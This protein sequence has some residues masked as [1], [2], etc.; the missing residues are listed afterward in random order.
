[1]SLSS[2]SEDVRFDDSLSLDKISQ[3]ITFYYSF[4]TAASSKHAALFTKELQ[5]IVEIQ[6]CLTETESSKLYRIP[7][8]W[9]V[10]TAREHLLAA[11]GCGFEVGLAGDTTK[12][13]E[14]Q[15]LPEWMLNDC[16]VVFL[17]EYLQRTD[18]TL[19]VYLKTVVEVMNVIPQHLRTSKATQFTSFQVH[20]STSYGCVWND[21]GKAVYKSQTILD[22]TEYYRFTLQT[23]W[24]KNM[25]PF[26]PNPN[27]MIYQQDM[28]HKSAPS[29]ALM[30]AA[31]NP[32]MDGSMYPL[33][34]K[35]LTGKSISLQVN[36]EFSIQRVKELIQND[37]GIPP[38]QQTLIFAGR[39]LNN[40]QTL[41]DYNIQ[42]YS[43]LHL[44]LRCRGGMLH[45][46]SGRKGFD[47]ISKGIGAEIRTTVELVNQAVVESRHQLLLILRHVSNLRQLIA[48]KHLMSSY[49]EG[50]KWIDIPKNLKST[51][52]EPL[53]NIKSNHIHSTAVNNPVQIAT[54]LEKNVV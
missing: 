27:E 11:Y 12:W 44:V 23:Q 43:T 38:D 3:L 50:L 19:K 31:V 51:I 48:E 6:I 52:F 39:Q 25:A 22:L 5:H 34:V 40:P 35:T 36:S 46:I 37:E 15:P 14:L 32:E 7:S 9:K 26:E 28:E 2:V 20:L 18:Q 47:T 13:T 17:P 45:Y 8:C 16:Y 29:L 21:I 30:I 4:I 10:S 24:L 49:G 1:M 42:P 33:F 53:I 41:A 54:V